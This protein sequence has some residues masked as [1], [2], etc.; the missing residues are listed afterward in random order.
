MHTTDISLIIMNKNAVLH[1]RGLSNNSTNRTFQFEFRLL[2][3]A[4]YSSSTK[5]PRFTAFICCCCSS[6]KIIFTPNP[7]LSL[8]QTNTPNTF[9]SFYIPTLLFPLLSI[10]RRLLRHIQQRVV[11]ALSP[12]IQHLRHRLHL[13]LVQHLPSHPILNLTL[14]CSHVNTTFFSSELIRHLNSPSRAP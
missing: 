4:M 2:S 12:L 3:C 5:G 8:Y 1:F 6:F 10:L 7:F 11:N 13:L 9:F 14:G